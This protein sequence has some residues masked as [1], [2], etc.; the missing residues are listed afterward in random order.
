[1]TALGLV[2]GISRVKKAGES[3]GIDGTVV[4]ELKDG[5]VKKLL[6]KYN[7]EDIYNADDTGL[8]WQILPEN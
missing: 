2:W 1:M 4:T 6:N 3:G 8:F 5:R 7:L